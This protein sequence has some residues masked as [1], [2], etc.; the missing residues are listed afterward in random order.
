MDPHPAPPRRPSFLLDWIERAGNRLPNPLTLFV[1][2]AGATVLASAL[3]AGLGWTVTHPKDGSTLSAVSLLNAEG[4]RR[5][6]TEALRNFTGF[7]PLG[8][9][10]VSMIG[11]GVAEA[12]GLVGVLLRAFVTS[13]PRRWL[14]AAVVFAAIVLPGTLA[15][16]KAVPRA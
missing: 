10:L 8:L 16:W 13:L 4:V 9:V 15:R 14:T 2:L 11:I 6:F 5:M 3:A 7:A 1:L 12:T